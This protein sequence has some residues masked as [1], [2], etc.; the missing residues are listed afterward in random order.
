MSSM[1]ELIHLIE[2]LSSLGR[3]RTKQFLSYS[4]GFIRE[5]L[6]LHWGKEELVRLDSREQKFSAKF[7][8]YIHQDNVFQI[9]D[10]LSLAYEHIESNGN[11]KIVMTDLVLRLIRL[12]K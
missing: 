1:L 12:I 6:L 3:E 7:S 5:N 10:D 11:E 9:I 8:A 2:E 4:I